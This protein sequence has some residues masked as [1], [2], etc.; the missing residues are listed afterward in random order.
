MLDRLR[1][2][3]SRVHGLFSMRRLDREFEQE[4]ETHLAMLAEDL[5]RRG[6]APGQA[7]REARIR[8]G[9]P[10]QLR[11]THR[12][13]RGLPSVETFFRDVRHGL[14]VLRK[15]P[16]FTAVAVLILSVGIGAAIT[17][18]SIVKVMVLGPLHYPDPGRLVQIWGGERESLLA[19]APLST[20]DYL[21][22]REQGTAFAESGAFTARLYNLGGDRPEAVRGMACTPGLL[23]ALGVQPVLGRWFSETEG[24]PGAGRVA[25][26]SHRWWSSRLSGDRSAV[27][28]AI[29][30]DGESYTVI[31]VMPAGFDVLS[32]VYS[33]Q[34]TDLW[35]P[36]ALDRGDG[37]RNI[38]WL[39][40][41]GRLKP[42]AT[43]QDAR[44]ELKTIAARVAKADSGANSG[45]RR[46]FWPVS[47]SLDVVGIA[48]IRLSW[49]M[50]AVW[51]VL[52]LASQNVAC[53]LLARGL[54]RQTEIAVRASMGA[55]RGHI[56]RL[57]L[58]ES[59]LLS[60]AAGAAGIVL[61]VIC[62][63][64]LE[65]VMPPAMAPPGGIRIDGWI[66]AMAA[67]I[68]AL[69][70]LM[71]GITPALVA[72]RTDFLATL[73]EGGN[74]QSGSKASLR[75]LRRLVIG[76]IAASL[77]LVNGAILLS[78]NYRGLLDKQRSLDSERVLTAG[79]A[80]NGENYAKPAAR[81]AFWE[82]LLERVRA[83]PGVEAAAVG[84][85]L[86]IEMRGSVDVLMEG[87]PF[88]PKTPRPF[89][90]RPVMSADYF[91]AAGISLVRGRYPVEADAR[92][93]PRN[94]VINRAMAVRFWPEQDPLGKRLRGNCPNCPW[95]M[96]AGVVENVRQRDDAPTQPEM[97]FPFSESPEREA[98]LIVRAR[99]D[100][101]FVTTA[102]QK[103]MAAL[104]S[105]LALDH[106]RTMREEFDSR[107][108]TT[109]F[110]TMMVNLF[111]AVALGL[112]AIG[113]YG[114]LSFHVAR[115]SRE[116]GV[117]MA[118]GAS[119]GAILR[120]VFRQ[121]IPWFATG[122]AVGLA[123]TILTAEIMRAAL[124]AIN[125]LDA[126]A[127]GAS[128]AVVIVPTAL[129]A[130]LPA[131]RAMRIDP[132]AALRSE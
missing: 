42:G 121:A 96:V 98:K 102:V 125:P 114:T 72:A 111:M 112:T 23:R 47:L 33:N 9:A 6:M 12:D 132:I 28:Q 11:E 87:Q 20:P 122:A 128:V 77:V 117:R 108:Q 62:L 116:F 94:I 101:R 86:P 130:W 110:L 18:A 24:Q 60:V 30:L 16:G 95:W 2:A 115:R 29:R 22:I 131:R 43:A 100:G 38:L 32:S 13:L 58:T 54:R 15:S 73:K 65:G 89:V 88:D 25:I 84:S 21:D 61:A 35:T 104:D 51:I 81:M 79:I 92:G 120:A 4:I 41:I 107:T 8:L 50:G 78:S 74:N 59:A 5:A 119:R 53:M 126:G 109:R 129:A 113:T 123:F 3:A 97:Y 67:G 106:P 82:R 57:M 70:A 31:G 39:P 44:A 99:G 17:V 63:R 19:H 124:D 93:T 40:V 7:L 64:A 52:S 27:G 90:E 127:V 37:R 68:S 76:Q 10:A 34:T 118:L 49:L 85:K 69:T 83:I 56:I 45:L 91:A 71:S 26:L 1:A 80:L 55:G 14:R 103:E 66:A 46:A 75:R 48:A 105:D 36:L